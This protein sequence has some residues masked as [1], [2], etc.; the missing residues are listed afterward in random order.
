AR[1]H[2]EPHLGC[3]GEA[4]EARAG[5]RTAVEA[6]PLRFQLCI[7]A[8]PPRPVVELGDH[9]VVVEAL[10]E[11]AGEAHPGA[12]GHPA[13]AERR[14]G[15]QRVV[16]TAPGD[17]RGALARN[18]DRFGVPLRVEGQD[19]AHPAGVDV[20]PTGH[21]HLDAVRPV[22]VDEV[23]RARRD[24]PDVG[25][26]RQHAP[27][28]PPGPR[29]AVAAVPTG[30]IAFVLHG[31]NHAV[32]VALVSTPHTKR[33][34]AWMRER[35]SKMSV[36]PVP[37]P[38]MPVRITWASC[39][40]GIS[41]ARAPRT[42]PSSRSTGASDSGTTMPMAENFT[43][44]A[45]ARARARCERLCT[46]RAPATASPISSLPFTRTSPPQSSL[47][48]AHSPLGPNTMWSSLPAGVST[49]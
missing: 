5:Q 36:P 47:T 41:S 31:R 13:L 3:G 9:V 35:S 1:T 40:C 10:T 45:R 2:G 34:A 8:H 28:M 30:A 21:G 33:T 27:A 18:V 19:A 29:V 24:R 22:V 17:A 37:I 43:R 46:G 16:A 26:G 48:S 38:G 11:V 49:S 23:A 20:A 6:E 44:A 7:R 39:G 32:A 14:D 4:V 15:Q 25:L 42:V 12:G